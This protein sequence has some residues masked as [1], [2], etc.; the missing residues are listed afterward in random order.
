MNSVRAI[1]AL[2]RFEL[3]HR[4]PVLLVAL[5]VG[6]ATLPLAAFTRQ[7]PVVFGVAL[8]VAFCLGAAGLLGSA[9]LAEPL[10]QGRI[11]F[12]LA[13]PIGVAAL[14]WGRL[15]G[16]TLVAVLAATAAV[17]PAWLWRATRLHGTEVQALQLWALGLLVA[18][19]FAALGHV[20]A[21]LG[22]SR[23]GRVAIDVAAAL[24]VAALAGAAWR[25]LDAAGPAG[26]AHAA[27][28]VP[29]ALLPLLCIAAGHAQLWRGRGDVPRGHLGLSAT[30]WSPLLVVSAGALAIVSWTL[31]LAPG[32]IHV[33]EEGKMV[34]AARSPWAVVEGAVLDTEPG[35][36]HRLRYGFSASF[37]LDLETGDWARLGPATHFE[38]RR[39]FPAATPALTADGGRVAFRSSDGDTYFVDL[40]R[41]RGRDASP[42]RA[43]ELDL[44]PRALPPDFTDAYAWAL[45]AD[46]QHLAAVL[47]RARGAAQPVG[48][49]RYLVSLRVVSLPEGTPVF[50][51]EL[52]WQAMS[53]ELSEQSLS[54]LSVNLRWVDDTRLELA[55]C[56][57]P[58]T[59]QRPDRVAGAVPIHAAFATLD[60]ARPGYA[61]ELTRIFAEPG[62]ARYQLS[63]DGR[64][65]VYRQTWREGDA[66]LRTTTGDTPV[67]LERPDRRSLATAVGATLG[68]AARCREG[69]RLALGL[70]V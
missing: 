11:G 10:S 40:P 62:C 68:R 49:G 28:V 41:S 44:T 58:T 37:L 2:M 53:D 46:G 38:R 52:P 13:Q 18:L 4:S 48:L 17:A 64:T 66:A 56:L 14:W 1:G 25:K 23:G 51:G 50:S 54:T 12:F 20:G 34:T 7:Q 59:P 16:V 39:R 67:S 15:L 30:L 5:A 57:A 35:W 61:P 21:T 32:D 33:R 63:S 31:D 60:L 19:P 69:A 3:A 43:R 29:V 55:G 9:M 8:G 47:V 26:A 22:R 24:V 70:P 65:A 42:H 45:S 6:I 36:P 27:W